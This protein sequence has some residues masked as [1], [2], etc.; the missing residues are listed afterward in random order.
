MRLDDISND[1]TFKNLQQTLKTRFNYQLNTQGLTVE[2]ATNM[3]SSMNESID[4]F[5][6]NVGRNTAE[7]NPEFLKRLMVSEALELF[8]AEAKNPQ[9]PYAVGMAQAMKST[10]D[11]PPLKKST[12]S[13]AHKI[14]KAMMKDDINRD[15]EA[16]N[17]KYQIRYLPHDSD[18]YKI[19]KGFLSK[20]E[21]EKYAKAENF[22][23]IADEYNVEIMKDGI[24]ED[25]D[26][27]EAEVVLATKDFSDRLNGMVED[28]GEM[29][30]EDL[31]PL[32][33]S[34]RD[35]VGS[36]KAEQYSQ[37][38][39]EVLQQALQDITTARDGMVKA[40]GL[41]TGES[42]EPMVPTDDSEDELGLDID[43]VADTD[44]DIEDELD[45][46]A[47]VSLGREKQD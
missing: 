8:I 11:E 2:K 40:T 31:Y 39:T 13:K 12:I 21:A 22:D 38:A 5:R 18:N 24:N 30:N 34:M 37:M 9:S 32:A 35:Q 19:V 27:G 23:E 26:T 14:A 33:D 4:K 1:Y 15:A 6:S 10:G 42:S 7:K 36:E 29:L 45:Q 47:P 3:L 17:K 43:D 44:L 16:S 28:I 46:E 25:V 20:A 41:I